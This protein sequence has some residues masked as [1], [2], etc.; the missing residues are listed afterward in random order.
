M[1]TAAARP[2]RDVVFSRARPVRYVAAAVRASQCRGDI[3]SAPG[4]AF[5]L[6]PWLPSLTP[7]APSR[8]FFRLGRP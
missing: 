4:P 8:C 2:P 5:P 7:R 6:L 3:S 1:T